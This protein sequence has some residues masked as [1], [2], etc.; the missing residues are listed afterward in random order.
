MIVCASCENDERFTQA[1]GDFYRDL[2]VSVTKSGANFQKGIWKKRPDQLRDGFAC[3]HCGAAVTILAKWIKAWKLDDEPA[4]VQASLDV[5]KLLGDLKKG[6]AGATLAL[7]EKPSQAGRLAGFSSLGIKLPQELADGVRER[8]GISLDKLYSH[9]VEALRHS[10][11]G[12]NVVL[13]TPTASGKSLCYLLPVFRTLLEDPEATALFVFP[14]KALAF[15]QRKKITVLAE[16]FDEYSLKATQFVWPLKFGRQTIHMG[17]YERETKGSDQ[18]AVK[19]KARIVVT[20]PD[21]L[22]TKILPYFNT[23]TGSWERFLRNLK[24][25]VLDE[26]HVY[27]GLF[28]AHVAWVNRRLRMM[29]DQLGTKP[30]FFC[31]SATLPDP[32]AHAED[33]VGLPF[34]AVTTTGAPLHR[35]V[36]GLWNPALTKKARG[37]V[38]AARKE[39][40]TDAIEVLAGALLQG[41]RPTQAITFMRT[42]AGVQRFD[43]TLRK[44]LKG[45]R[46][47]AS[48][49]TAAYSGRLLLRDRDEI[50]EG[51]MS[52]QVV[53]VTSTNALELGIDIGDLNACLM[54]GYPGTVSSFLQQSGRVGRKGPSIVLM[55]LKDEPLEQWFARNPDQFFRHIEKVEP[56]RLPARNP[57]VM[58]QQALCAAWD[59]NPLRGKKAPLK[60]L[61]HDLFV[62]YF[63]KDAQEEIQA[64][65][66]EKK[67]EPPGFRRG[68]S[69][70]V[71]RERYE[72]VYQ[73][74]R[75]PISI[76]KFK[77]IDESGKPVGECDSTIVPRDLFPGAIW[78]NNGRLFRSKQVKYRDQEVLVKELEEIDYYTIA[79]PQTSITCDED[80]ADTRDVAE[81][82]LGRG[83]VTVRREVKLYREV[84]TSSEGGEDDK[85]KTTRTDPIEYDSTAFWIDVPQG[86]L[87]KWKIKAPDAKPAMHALEHALRSVFPLVADVDPGDVGSTLEVDTE[88]RE[89]RCRLYIF[90]SFAGGTG[91]SDYAFE[92]PRSLLDAAENLL[93]SCT[94]GEDSGCPRCTIISWCEERNEELSKAG[95]KKLLAGLKAIP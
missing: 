81:C 45:D 73:S 71:V 85:V 52:R 72:D 80:A 68:G 40:T 17:S 24:F 86:T 78:M 23:K 67:V 44:R 32:K 25:V 65:L 50:A 59:L 43:H 13:Q 19:S 26:I 41:D 12:R 51:L 37:A 29:C 18:E 64:I 75:V 58:A 21:S 16:D 53:H 7:D 47:P 56:L 34:E 22:H 90:D 1:T 55:F 8:M 70:W 48:D 2:H 60:G 91:L 94:C 31:S 82:V 9:Q 38:T 4:V 87:R 5:D 83:P 46:N 14:T 30:Q 89:T 93:S 36:I 76:G 3:K 39:P 84:P 28:G 54:I 35:K 20:N 92:N 6:V 10:F 88:G 42:L 77:V 79:M 62:R 74:I 15:D 57:Y 66:D 69:Y 11:A 95:A 49:K 63:G 27:R 33:L 61:T